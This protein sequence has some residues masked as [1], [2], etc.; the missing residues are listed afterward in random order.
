[1]SHLCLGLSIS[2]AIEP[3]LQYHSFMRSPS[4]DLMDAWYLP[5][6]LVLLFELGKRL[7]LVPR[8]RKP[9]VG[10]GGSGRTRS[11][12]GLHFQEFTLSQNRTFLMIA[13]RPLREPPIRPVLFLRTVLDCRASKMERSDGF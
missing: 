2:F 4:S 1:M 13:V 10:M 9:T 8:A 11:P 3:N 5:S 6:R 7:P 12:R